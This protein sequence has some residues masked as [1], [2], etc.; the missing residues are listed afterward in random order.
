MQLQAEGWI[1]NSGE[2]PGQRLLTN[3][4]FKWSMGFSVANGHSG[5]IILGQRLRCVNAPLGKLSQC[6]LDV[7]FLFSDGSTPSSDEERDV[8]ENF[9]LSGRLPVYCGSIQS[10]GPK[11][12]SAGG[13]VETLGNFGC[14][15]LGSGIT[16]ANF[17]FSG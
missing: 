6:H 2:F 8:Q 1:G 7:E 11:S 3:V 15:G 14:H 9:R 5:G 16:A 13:C 4:G 17:E 12:A 10:A